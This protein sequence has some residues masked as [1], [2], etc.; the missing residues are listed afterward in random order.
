MVTTIYVKPTRKEGRV[1][2]RDENNVFEQALK[3]TVICSIVA[4]SSIIIWR[5]YK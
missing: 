1:Q 4:A 5:Q 3:L 2:Y